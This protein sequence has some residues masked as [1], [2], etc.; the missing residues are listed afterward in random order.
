M[1]SALLEEPGVDASPNDKISHWKNIA[2][3]IHEKYIALEKEYEEFES[4]YQELYKMVWQFV[5]SFLE[6]EISSL[7]LE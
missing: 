3:N 6:P 2:S 5:V 1:A 4:T 7:L